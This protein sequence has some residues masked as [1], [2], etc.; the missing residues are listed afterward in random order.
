MKLK[1][2]L[3]A[4][5]VL[6]PL[7]AIVAWA[8]WPTDILHSAATRLDRLYVQYRP[9]PYRWDGVQ[10]TPAKAYQSGNCEPVAGEK[11]NRAAIAIEDAERRSGPT[12]KSM[13]LRG[14]IDLL[15]CDT[16][17]AIHTYKLALLVQP[18]DSS[19]NLELG[20]AFAL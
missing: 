5:C 4:G 8:L 15:R 6:L 16:A 20:I 13:Q 9:F 10:F 2:L 12:V 7:A 3:L 11:L 17:S 14:R 18:N 19:L 1:P